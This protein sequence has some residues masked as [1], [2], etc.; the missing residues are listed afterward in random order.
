MV[1]P[2]QILAAIKADTNVPSACAQKGITKC[3]QEYI[4]IC[5]WMES[6]LLGSTT[7]GSGIMELLMFIS[8]P[9]KIMPTAAPIVKARI[10]LIILGIIFLN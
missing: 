7:S 4:C 10:F 9:F 6:R 8:H 2:S 3:F 1:L 5:V